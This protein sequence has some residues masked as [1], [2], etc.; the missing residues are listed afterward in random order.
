METV[1]SSPPADAELHLLTEWEEAGAYERRRKAVI[2][3]I[4]VHVLVIAGLVF[5]PATI[6]QTPEPHE[7]PR[8]IT[9]L[10]APTLTQK[11][12]NKGKVTAEFEVRAEAPRPK[13]QAPEAPPRPKQPPRPAVIPQAPAPKPA[14]PVSMPEA[15]KLALEAPQIKT[16]L[17]PVA[18]PAAPL[19]QIQPVEQPKIMLEN[20]GG[21]RQ[22]VP[23]NVPRLPVPNSSVSAA[24]H[25]TV[26]NSGLGGQAVGDAGASDPT[27][28][29]GHAP[30]S[31]GIPGAS[32]E[33]KSDPMGVD[34]K[35]YLQQILAAIKRNWLAV[36]PESVKM[37][38]RGRVALQ[39]RI[40][41]D[42][43]VVRLV[44]AEQSGSRPLDEAAVAG[45]SASNPLPPLPGEFKGE[46]IVVQFNFAYNMPRR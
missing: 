30:P 21:P 17:P 18:Q 3:T 14:A 36:I 9:P 38:L 27:I 22:G 19:P 39:F 10:I 11:A 45:V 40:S 4:G 26:H 28:F 33:L 1:A 12:P 7:A 24:V 31:P 29:G 42:G 46:S 20:A 16:D 44:Y 5:M 43:R 6:L 41:K 35:P 37:G 23:S 13:L 32:L 34:F 2:G 25:D 15:P 8:I